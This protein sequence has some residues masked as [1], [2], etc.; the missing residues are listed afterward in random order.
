MDRVGPLG[1]PCNENEVQRLLV[2]QTLFRQK[3]GDPS[4]VGLRVWSKKEGPLFS[5]PDSQEHGV[6]G[7]PTVALSSEW[8]SQN[9]S[10]HEPEP[11]SGLV[12]RSWMLRG[13][14]DHIN[15]A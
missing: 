4:Q 5:P 8:P 3:H 2:L 12:E 10:A 11:S 14:R 15:K 13:I 6:H 9:C 7:L 1:L